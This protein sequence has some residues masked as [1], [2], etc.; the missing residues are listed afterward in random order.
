[1]AEL[2]SDEAGPRACRNCGE[3]LRGAYCHACGESHRHRRLELR[4][5]LVEIAEGLVNPD[6]PIPRTISELT[7][8]PGRLGRDYLTGRRKPYL[9]PLGYVLVT[10]VFAALV[11]RGLAWMQGPPGDPQL[12]DLSAFTLGWG[13]AIDF[14]LIPLFALCVY[15]LFYG[16]PRLGGALGAPRQ[17]EWIEHYVLALFAFGHVALLLGLSFPFWP[18]LGAAVPALLVLGAIVYL[19]W[20]CVG[21]YRTPWW[22]TLLRV[23][24]AFIAGI[25]VPAGLLGRLIAPELF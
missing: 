10:G 20:M 14:A 19:S 17:L 16:A 7:V 18:Y 2:A 12:A 3:R 21:V 9:N 13:L 11:N 6:K 22:S 4:A 5:L 24:V 8:D 23:G 15:A 1:M 25:Q